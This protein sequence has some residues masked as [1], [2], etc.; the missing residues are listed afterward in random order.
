MKIHF[1]NDNDEIKTAIYRLKY[2]EHFFI[3]LLMALK[4][5]HI[6][7][8][9]GISFPKRGQYLKKIY[10]SLNFELTNAQIR[11]LREIRAD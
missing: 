3:Q 6:K 9:D 1:P 10:E 5:Y 8:N 4:K 2:N 7:K 11:V